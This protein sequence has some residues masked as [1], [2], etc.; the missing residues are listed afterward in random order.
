VSRRLIA[1]RCWWA[2]SLNFALRLGAF[3]ALACPGADQVALE[4]GQPA[5]HV[6]TGASP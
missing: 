2:V 4:L 5:K 1:S 6:T 3:P